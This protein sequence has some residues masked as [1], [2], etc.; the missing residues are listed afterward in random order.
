[1]LNLQIIYQIGVAAIL[2][3]ALLGFV[4]LFYVVAPYGRHWR[5]NFGPSLNPRIG[6]VLMELPSVVLFAWIYLRG[7]NVTQPVTLVLFGLMAVALCTADIHL[8]TTHAS[9]C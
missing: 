1:M 7:T 4:M 8:S 6:F 5:S 2:L 3:L 9:W